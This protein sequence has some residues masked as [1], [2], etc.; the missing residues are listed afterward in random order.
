MCSLEEEASSRVHTLWEDSKWSS[1]RKRGTDF[2]FT[3]L[4]LDRA[5]PHLFTGGGSEKVLMHAQ[6]VTFSQAVRA[7]VV[8]CYVRLNLEV[9]SGKS[10]PLTPCMVRCR[11]RDSEC[12]WMSVVV[13]F[14]RN[15]TVPTLSVL[16]LVRYRLLSFGL[17]DA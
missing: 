13:G 4:Q 11:S 16:I 5:K 17:R 2:L 6:Y 12:A 10:H 9:G 7:F 1:L 15:L 3:T 8:S 14:S